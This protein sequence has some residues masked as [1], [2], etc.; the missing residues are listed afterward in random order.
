[1]NRNI[2]WGCAVLV[3][4]LACLSVIQP[5]FAANEA[6]I[7][8]ERDGSMT[9]AVHKIPL[10][11]WDGEK[12]NKGDNF[13]MPF[14]TRLTCGE[15]HNYEKIASGWHFNASEEE[16]GRPSEPWF[17]SSEATGTQ[18]PVSE[19]GWEGTWKPGDLGLSPWRFV[20][21]FGSHMPGGGIGEEEADPPDFSARWHLSGKLEINCMACHS[22]SAMYDHAEW[23]AQIGKENFAWASTAAS[24]LASVSGTTKE[25]GPTFDI[26]DGPSIR[27]P[28][29]APPTVELNEAFLDSQSKA[30]FDVTGR[31][32]NERCYFCHSTK[33]DD[34]SDAKLWEGDQDV[35]LLA[36]MTC[37]DCHRNGIDH[38]IVR[39]TEGD[40]NGS[41]ASL[42]CRG[43]H[44]GT[45]GEGP[46][47]LAGRFGAPMPD[48]AGIPEV[49]FEKMS[50][51]SC[52]SGPWPGESTGTIRTSRAHKLGVH[53]GGESTLP[54]IVSP[55]YVRQEDGILEPRNITWPSFWAKVDGDNV[56]PLSSKE[57]IA[58]SRGILDA[59]LQV[60]RVLYA[61]SGVPSVPGVPLFIADGNAYKR[62]GNGLELVGPAGDSAKGSWARLRNGEIVPIIDPFE[63]TDE[64]WDM[65]PETQMLET[66]EFIQKFS[67]L[68]L[69]PVIVSD[70]KVYWRTTDEYVEG[71]PNEGEKP[72]GFSLAFR[73]GGAVT[74]PFADHV[75]PTIV[76]TVGT[77]NTF[78]EVQVAMVLDALAGK[79]QADFAYVVSGKMFRSDGSGKLNASEHKSAEPYSWPIAHNVRSAGRSLGANGCQDCHSE[80]AGFFFGKVQ[81]P[82][83][84][85]FVGEATKL[86]HEISGIDA[87]L[88]QTWA[89][90]IKLKKIYVIGGYAIAIIIALGLFRYGFAALETVAGFLVQ[91]GKV[92]GN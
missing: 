70:K 32:S 46:D 89:K 42:S 38:K 14:S 25:L 76:E 73:E 52:H 21:L 54:I 18:L 63:E 10:L 57:V 33:H 59:E 85:A 50:C 23:A 28:K 20:K 61:L 64:D 37:V 58:A 2:F 7:N 30:F 43:C 77:D 44:L 12:I 90:A 9:P 80:E 35:H 34:G 19:R 91:R 11:D 56:E 47:S 4:G 55:V 3:A 84:G 66:I 86:Q 40:P 6:L 16:A 65:L 13:V 51:T 48:H 82:K 45:S 41:S 24:Q 26:Y 68:S 49:H 17:L 69:E 74:S 78:T 53:T 83:P 8:K 72:G 92:K 71:T 87:E 88:V 75:V 79:E 67:G 81:V 15:C 62:D 22:G 39:G 31:P 60:V 36:G 29:I 1:M 5:C 27:D